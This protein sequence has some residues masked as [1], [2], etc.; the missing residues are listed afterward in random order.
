LLG[1]EVSTFHML[2]CIKVNQQNIRYAFVLPVYACLALRTAG[3]GTI[4]NH[5]VK[6]DVHLSI[7]NLHLNMLGK[8]FLAALFPLII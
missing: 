3:Q 6:R 5:S 7:V 1:Y 8:L 4:L 2:T